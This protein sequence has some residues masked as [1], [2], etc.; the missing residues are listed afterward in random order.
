MRDIFELLLID[1]GT[2]VACKHDGSVLW[3]SQERGSDA[4]L[5]QAKTI[6]TKRA[7]RCSANII[8]TQTKYV[9]LAVKLPMER[10]DALKLQ[11]LV[12]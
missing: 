5:L 11:S 6:K 9:C 1:F 10:I 8:H 2:F 3:L 12:V 4:L 7:T